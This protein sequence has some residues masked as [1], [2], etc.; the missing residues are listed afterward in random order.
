M[1]HRMNDDLLAQWHAASTAGKPCVLVTVAATR[2]SVPRAAGAKM[3]VLA[4]GTVFGTV[5][6]G[7]FESLVIADAM[8]TLQQTE[9]MLKTYPLHE[10]DDA[11]FGAICGGEVTIL[12]EPAAPRERLVIVGNG[13]CAHALARLA[14]D[15]GWHVTVLDDREELFRDF[16]PV[17]LRL[18]NRAPADFID[19]HPWQAREALVL[20]SRSYLIDRDSLAAALQRPQI[21]YLG[22]IGSE[23]KVRKV[24]A[25]LETEGLA[26]R[27][28]IAQVYSPIG[29]DI[30]SDSPAEIAVSIIAEIL[31]VL[32]KRQ[33]SHLRLTTTS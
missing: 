31:Q 27:E 26:T 16:P 21:A 28:Q 25:H 10:G 32:R 1:L 4:D 20:V 23:R 17:H 3:L 22:M 29:L 11:S 8:A 13:H 30:G 24:F 12:L 5:G 14:L 9:P 15:C 18:S 6:G 7:K 2:G 19:Q 33:G